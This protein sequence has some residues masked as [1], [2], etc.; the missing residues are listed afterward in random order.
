[1]AFLSGDTLFSWSYF[2]KFLLINTGN[3]IKTAVGRLKKKPQKAG[4]KKFHICLATSHFHSGKVAP[5]FEVVTLPWPPD[6]VSCENVCLEMVAMDTCWREGVL[7]W[8]GD[9]ASGKQENQGKNFMAAK[10]LGDCRCVGRRIK[11][12]NKKSKLYI[13][14]TWREGRGRVVWWDDDWNMWPLREFRRK[15]T[16]SVFF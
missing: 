7:W 16:T 15:F 4:P 14:Q 12:K 5:D 6:L 3:N 11:N 1:M 8:V 10:L 9:W 13:L 2:A